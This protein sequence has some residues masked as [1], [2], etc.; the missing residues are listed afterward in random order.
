MHNAHTKYLFVFANLVCEW[1]DFGI[2][3]LLGTIDPADNNKLW[4]V[5]HRENGN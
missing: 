4:T 3:H 1:T 2:G 5:S